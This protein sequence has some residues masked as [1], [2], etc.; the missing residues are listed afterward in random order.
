MSATCRTDGP[1]LQ[2]QGLTKDYKGFRAIEDVSFEAKGGEIFGL[3]GP[4]G[5]GKTTT[6]R[7]ISAILSPTSGTARICGYDVREAPEAVRRNIGMLTTE[8]GVYDRLSGR[9][10]LRYFGALYSMGSDKTERRIRDLSQLLEMED[11]LDRRTS[12]YSTG[13]KQKLSIARSVLHDPSIV[14]LDEPTSG[15]DVLAAQTVLNFMRH[16]REQ[17]RLVV[18]ST[19]HMPDAEKL[20]DRA[21]IM[22]H[23][24]LLAVRTISDLKKDTGTNNLEDAFLSMVKGSPPDAK[25]VTSNPTRPPGRL[26]VPRR[27][28]I[29]IG[30]AVAIIVALQ[31]WR[32]L[33]R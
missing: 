3:L 13:M 29:R 25:M 27:L 15:L 1:L 31:L 19:H 10:Y 7:L 26:R 14:I 9:E 33:T 12:S 18:L 28:L 6:I 21:A 17:G 22:H 20:C 30:I 4:N 11:F 16:S 32:L 23:G 24:K 2:V 5:A 8:M